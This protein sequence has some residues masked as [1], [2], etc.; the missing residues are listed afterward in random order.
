V[1]VEPPVE[2]VGPP[3]ELVGVMALNFHCHDI[4]RLFLVRRHLSCFGSSGG[5]SGFMLM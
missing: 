1:V 2:L 5:K 4:Q 3:V